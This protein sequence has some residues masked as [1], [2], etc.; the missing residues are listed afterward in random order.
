MDRDSTANSK[1]R[2]RRDGS[3]VNSGLNP[4]DAVDFGSS[5]AS[6]VNNDPTPKGTRPITHKQQ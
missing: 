3:V 1:K 5:L 2:S 6:S 4:I